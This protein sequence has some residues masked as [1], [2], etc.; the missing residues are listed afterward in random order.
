LRHRHI[1]VVEIAIRSIRVIYA[2]FASQEGG[3]LKS[4]ARFGWTV[5]TCL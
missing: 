1:K 2:F 5:R 3:P 4:P